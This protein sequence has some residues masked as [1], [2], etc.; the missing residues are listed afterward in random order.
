MV[1]TTI[2]TKR[3]FERNTLL[4]KKEEKDKEINTQ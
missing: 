4:V 3:G 1:S 2:S